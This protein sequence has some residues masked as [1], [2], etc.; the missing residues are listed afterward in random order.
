MCGKGITNA[1]SYKQVIWPIL[2]NSL[3]TWY[4]D[5]NLTFGTNILKN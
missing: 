5:Y 2:Y 1:F 3:N 4:L